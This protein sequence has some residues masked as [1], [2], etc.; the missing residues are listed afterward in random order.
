MEVR[1]A[2]SHTKKAHW[3][4]AGICMGD[5]V[6]LY[7]IS[8]CGNAV[9]G[10]L[11]AAIMSWSTSSPPD[12]L[13]SFESISSIH[14]R[15]SNSLRLTWRHGWYSCCIRRFAVFGMCLH[16]Y[17]VAISLSRLSTI[18][19]ITFFYIRE[20]TVYVHVIASTCIFSCYR[21]EGSWNWKIALYLVDK[22]F[23]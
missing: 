3:P 21:E 15:N 2:D 22:V 1:T 12:W 17:E 4:C 8:I 11:N 19:T 9:R 5:F 10:T 20:S 7:F 13:A 18:M 14:C 16:F 23:W 6:W